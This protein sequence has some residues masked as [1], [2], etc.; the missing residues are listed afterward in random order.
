VAWSRAMVMS[1]GGREARS[2]LRTGSAR[3]RTLAAGDALALK[4]QSLPAAN[5]VCCLHSRTDALAWLAP[6]VTCL[7]TCIIGRIKGQEGFADE[8]CRHDLARSIRR[9]SPRAGPCWRA[10]GKPA[11]DRTG[12]API[13]T[14]ADGDALALKPQSL[15]AANMVCCLHRIA[16][17]VT[18]KVTRYKVTSRTG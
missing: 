7:V 6:I 4:A 10:H 9:G 17:V 13:R 14:L 8:S 2:G 11:P 12:S 5:M 16:P 1:A 15:P 3:I 18:L